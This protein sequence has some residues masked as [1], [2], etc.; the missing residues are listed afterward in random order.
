MMRVGIAAD[1]GSFT[2]KVQ[3]LSRCRRLRPHGRWSS[4]FLK[5][6]TGPTFTNLAVGGRKR[7]KICNCF[8]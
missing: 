4:Q 6:I 5:P 2:L 3:F 7:L 8:E 1:H